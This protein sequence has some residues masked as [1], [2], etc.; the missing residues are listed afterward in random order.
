M[1]GQPGARILVVDDEPAIRRVLTV[2]LNR[3]GYAVETAERGQEALIK[4]ARWHPDLIILD[5]GLPDIDG[6]TVIRELRQYATT[7]I[8]VLSVRE[9]E[10]VK[11][12]ALDLGADDYVTKPFGVAELL[13]RIRVALRHA[14]RPAHG[15]APVIQAGAITVD[16]EH[17]QVF[18][19]GREIR[20]TP[21]EWELLK[22]FLTH[23]NKPLTDRYL[24]EHVWGPEFSGADHYLHVY[25]AR[26]RKKLEPDPQQPTHLRTEPGVGYRFVIPD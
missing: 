23:P 19:N 2:T 10:A 7:P 22:V 16:L 8:V 13:A 18:V 15:S 11:V 6:L 1:T 20:L 4:A 25:I 26:L 14:A 17:R 9:A 5:L 21:T 24:L 12:Q 3:H